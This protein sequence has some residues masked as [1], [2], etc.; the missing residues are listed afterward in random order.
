M[1]IDLASGE[2]EPTPV[3]LEEA[4]VAHRERTAVDLEDGEKSVTLIR[5]HYGYIQK[6]GRYISTVNTQ[7]ILVKTPSLTEFI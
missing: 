4:F 6:R 7:C 2:I 5:R 1:T 3:I